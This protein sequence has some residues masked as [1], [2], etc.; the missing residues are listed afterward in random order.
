VGKMTRAFTLANVV[1]AS[2]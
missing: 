1:G 2:S